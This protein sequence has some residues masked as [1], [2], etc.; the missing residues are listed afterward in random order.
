MKKSDELLKQI[1]DKTEACKN[2]HGEE[3]ANLFEEIKALK[4]DREIELELEANELAQEEP[5]IENKI[6][7]NRKEDV[8]MK[9]E[10]SLIHAMVKMAKRKNLTVEEAQAIEEARVMNALTGEEHILVKDFSTKVK[11]LLR[12]EDSLRNLVN[13]VNTNAISGQFPVA[14]H[15]NAGLVTVVDGVDMTADTDLEFEA[16][17]FELEKLGCLGMLTDTVLK[18]SAPD[19]MNYL[20]KELVKR[21][22]KTVNEKVVE[23]AKNRAEVEVANVKEMAK[24]MRS[25]IDRK[26]QNGAVIL[27]S[28]DGFEKLVENENALQISFVQPDIT[29]EPIARINGKD[30]VIVDNEL[31]PQE[32]GKEVILYGNFKEAI[33]LFEAGQYHVSTF[34]DFLKNVTYAKLIAYMDAV[35]VDN[36]A[37]IKMF[38]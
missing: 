11:E 7:E 30:V 25:K 9:N 16:I 12:A 3:K 29:K 20:A 14:K 1:Q 28:V 24:A 23:I 37:I 35:E 33:T 19:L 15:K 36:E 18:F 17:Q 38:I 4:K 22:V 32:G 21:Y 13:C 5:K 34:A 31:L 10:V 2:A 26:L 8:K 27:C 6:I